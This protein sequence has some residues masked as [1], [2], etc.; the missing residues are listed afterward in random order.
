MARFCDSVRNRAS[1]IVSTARSIASGHQSTVKGTVHGSVLGWGGSQCANILCPREAA[2]VEARVVDG[3]A[4]AHAAASTS[5]YVRSV[6]RGSTDRGHR[7]GRGRLT[8]SRDPRSGA[9]PRSRRRQRMVR[10]GSPGDRVPLA[11]NS[12]MTPETCDAPWLYPFL[13]RSPPDSY[14]PLSPRGRANTRSTLPFGR[15]ASS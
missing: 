9:L 12:P 11:A 15:A 4:E 5:A 2:Q 1:A 10:V 8:R 14:C 13:V 3:V 6:V 7:R